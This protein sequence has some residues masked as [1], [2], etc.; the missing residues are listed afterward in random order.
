MRRYLDLLIQTFKKLGKSQQIA[1]GGGIVLVVILVLA[2]T[3]FGGK[4]RQK[5]LFPGATL[6]Y[7]E[8]AAITAVLTDNGYTFQLDGT[9]IMVSG[10]DKDKIMMILA[11][12]DILPGK[13]KTFSELFG[14]G[15]GLGETQLVQVL[16]KQEALQGS[17]ENAIRS[18]GSIDDVQV[19]LAIPPEK[20]FQED[21]EEVTASVV[22][23]MKPFASLEKKQVK[24]IISLVAHAVPGLKPGN[25]SVVNSLGTDLTERLDFEVG[26]EGPSTDRKMELQRTLEKYLETKIKKMLDKVLGPGKSEVRVSADLNFDKLEKKSHTI[27]PPVEGEESGVAIS[28]QKNEEKW[29]GLGVTPG[30]VPGTDSNIP[31]YQSK[32]GHEKAEYTK[33]ENMTNYGFNEENVSHYLSPG[34]LNRL[35]VSVVIDREKMT[36]EE[37][38]NFQE[39]V[40]H[41]CGLDE[42]RKD[43]IHLMNYTF[44]KKY[45]EEIEDARKE[46]RYE[47]MRKVT[48]WFLLIFGLVVGLPVT[49][50]VIT[51]LRKRHLEKLREIEEQRRLAARKKVFEPVLSVEEMEK[52]QM[53]EHVKQQAF[54]H[55][56]DFAQLLKVWLMED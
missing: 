29:N 13:S 27:T 45:L 47:Y 37:K 53:Q 52:K 10:R 44:D 38:L 14:A 2:L 31:G 32:L 3:L 48:I 55:P 35:T 43:S 28:D 6:S 12:A 22:I 56:E 20:L 18:M 17:L 11:Q 42:S 30:G 5:P 8:A 16:K 24:A 34:T 25:I 15:A 21:Q 19:L 54:E 40:A 23:S 51:T 46:S 41:A 50:K 49:I 9:K 1:V 36:D 4:G 39:L 7:E 33:T 26:D